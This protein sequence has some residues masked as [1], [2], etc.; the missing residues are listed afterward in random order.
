[1]TDTQPPAPY[2]PTTPVSVPGR[3]LG[4]VGLVVDF[5]VPLVGLILSIVARSQSKKAAV[6]NTPAKIGVIL[7]IIFLIL[8]IIGIIIFIV[9]IAGVASHCADLG[10]GVH[11]LNGTRYTCS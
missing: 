8:Q 3:V 9:V 6:P 11:E 5:F 2:V 4:I 10:P 1:M 7:G